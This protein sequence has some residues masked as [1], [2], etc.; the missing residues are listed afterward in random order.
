M[1]FFLKL[2]VKHPIQHIVCLLH[3]LEIHLKH[4]FIH[5]DKKPTGPSCYTGDIGSQLNQV[6]QLQPVHFKTVD[7]PDLPQFDANELRSDQL[8]LYEAFMTV[9]TGTI[10][11]RFLKLD[12][13]KLNQSRW[14]TLANRILRL[15][16][17][18]ISPSDN[19]KT[20]VTFVMKVK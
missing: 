8:Y 10:A 13:G 11:D 5:L 12:P 1:E 19:L 6:E 18:T 15:Y 3:L 4:V 17:C 16:I 7:A 2:E 20:L 14:M 9:K